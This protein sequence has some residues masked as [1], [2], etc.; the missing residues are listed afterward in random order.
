MLP[1]CMNLFSDGVHV[2][3]FALPASL[4]QPTLKGRCVRLEVMVTNFKVTKLWKDV[5]R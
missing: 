5:I 1:N 2:T 4:S 3:P